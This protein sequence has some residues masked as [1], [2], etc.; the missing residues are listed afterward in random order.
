MHVHTSHQSYKCPP[1]TLHPW[2]WT[3]MHYDVVH[4]TFVAIAQDA[5][6]HMGW[7]Q[8]HT[9]PL[10]TFHFSHWEVDIVIT[11]DGIRTL[12]NIVIA[13]PTWM[14][15]LTWSY[16]T[17]GFTTSKGTQTKERNYCDWHPTYHFL[18]LA[19]EALDVWTNKL[20]SS[21]MTVPMPC[22]I[23]KGQKALLFFLS[24]LLFYVK[25]SQLHYKGCKHPSS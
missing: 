12:A 24:W 8:L 4:N 14:D 23:S 5:N 9:L 1:F 25:Q 22:G 13:N 17:R 16:T 20:I 15:L 7:K 19:I 11:K 21:Y 6:F 2:Q 3:H 10:T 18:L